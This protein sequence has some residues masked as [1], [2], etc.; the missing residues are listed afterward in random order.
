[1]PALP[2]G[3]AERTE[4]LAAIRAAV[5][6]AARLPADRASLV[7]IV[8]N[9]KD[10][11]TPA[12]AQTRMRQRRQHG[13]NGRQQQQQ[14]QQ[15]EHKAQLRPALGLM[16]ATAGTTDVLVEVPHDA[17]ETLR[18]LGASGASMDFA[19]G[20]AGAV[21]VN[22]VHLDGE[23]A[24]YFA[25][26]GANVVET[27]SDGESTVP[28]WVFVLVTC[29]LVAMMLMLAVAFALR[30]RS[31]VAESKD[32]GNMATF[33]NSGVLEASYASHSVNHQSHHA[34][35]NNSGYAQYQ[36]SNHS[37]HNNSHAQH[38]QPAA[39]SM[40]SP[41]GVPPPPPPLPEATQA[42]PPPPPISGL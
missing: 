40:G 39:Q 6:N 31:L 34:G 18:I 8:D 24:A 9:V 35:D 1:V 17:A 25:R 33:N 27:S 28:V 16:Q 42:P 12:D 37:S 4:R 21:D 19:G 36:H 5:A 29:I 38:Y 7:R 41:G 14:Q 26:P 2:A 20:A 11:Y 32:E 13:P 30:V 10:K 15:Q 3:S 22:T 23:P